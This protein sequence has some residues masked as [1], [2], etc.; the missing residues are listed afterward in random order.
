MGESGRIQGRPGGET[1]VK[2]PPILLAAVAVALLAG[3]AFFA[4]GWMKPG[5]DPWPETAGAA[6]KSTLAEAKKRTEA[7][8]K[9]RQ[10]GGG[11]TENRPGLSGEEGEHRVFVSP[12][13]VFLPENPEPVQPLDRKMKTSDGIEVGWK[14]KYEFEPDDP[15]VASAD[16]DEDGF[17]N[18]EEFTEGTDP[19]RKESSPAKETKLRTRAARLAKLK[20]SFA[21][22]SGGIYSI[23]FQT[24]SK[25]KEFKGKKGDVFWL[26]AG[27]DTL[28]GFTDEGKLNAAREKAKGSDLPHHAIPLRFADYEEKIEKVKDA[29]VGGIEVEMDNSVVTLERKDAL[30]GLHKLIFSPPQRPHSL[31]W[32]VGTVKFFTPAGGGKEIGTYQEGETFLYEGKEFAVTSLLEGGKAKLSN[33]NEPGKTLIV[34]PEAAEPAAPAPTPPAQ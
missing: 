22:K 29:K 15:A 6:G 28:E 14:M 19:T 8:Q 33:L 23:R 31:V 17:T 11:K 13:L 26:M 18:L 7:L 9:G 16:P 30:P 10:K 27:P 4:V 34:P 32:E 21:E 25:P 1:T 20:I 2:I 5:L 3:G 12:T 24:G